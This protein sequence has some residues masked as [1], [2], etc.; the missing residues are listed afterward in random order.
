M[1]RRM[2]ATCTASRTAP[3]AKAPQPV[4]RPFVGQASSWRDLGPAGLPHISMETKSMKTAALFLFCCAGFAQSSADRILGALSDRSLAEHTAGM[5][6]DD[7]IAMYSAMVGSK[8]SEAHYQVL[9]ASAY[10]QKTRE[11]TDY[12]YLDKAAGILDGVVSSDGANYEAQRLLVETE[13]EKHQFAGAA[14]SSRRLIR[15]S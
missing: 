8:P 15:I 11:T 13:L 9:L 10:I 3:T 4:T 1:P 2:P 6:T 5:K 12:S 7:R 14:A